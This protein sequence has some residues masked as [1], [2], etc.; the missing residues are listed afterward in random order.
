MLGDAVEITDGYKIWWSY[1]PH[2]IG[3]PGYVYAYAFGYLFSLAIF[4][5]YE[6]EGPA[7]VGPYLDLLRAGGSDTPEVLARIVGLD[8]SDPGFWAEG[9]EAVDRLLAEAEALAEKTGRA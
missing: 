2:F 8:L 9:L 6:K 5:R 1:I 7:I 3:A 4:R